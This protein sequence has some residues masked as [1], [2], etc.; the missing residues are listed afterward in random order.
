MAADFKS[1]ITKLSKPTREVLEGALQL[2]KSRTNYDAD[3]P[4]FLM[5]ALERDDLDVAR[6]VRA[7]GINKPVLLGDLNH[8]L[9]LLKRGS[10][11]TPLLSPAV[12]RLFLLHGP[13][14][15]AVRN[16]Q[17]Y[18]LMCHDKGDG[19]MY[20]EDDRL[21]ISWP[22]V[23]E[24]PIFERANER[25]LEAT[26]PLGGTYVINPTWS[27]L[28]KHNLITV[29]PL[30]GCTMSDDAEHGVVNHKGQVFSGKNGQDVH[31][32]L[33]VSDGSIIPRPLGVNPFLTISALAERNSAL[34]AQDRGW[35][36]DYTL[37][38]APGAEP[39]KP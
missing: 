17:T 1:L 29:H 31:K 20:L 22:G 27:T 26:R 30:G 28:T 32:G 33:Y 14:A 37:P 4:H 12:L 3:L 24:Q 39:Q 2:C 38:S 23:G 13:Y 7:F 36:I 5:K 19:K 6:I 15:G 18:L 9:D 10:G 21:R 8:A 11:S 16:T 25:L 35:K 34:L